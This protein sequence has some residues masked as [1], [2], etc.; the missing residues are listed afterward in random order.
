MSTRRTGLLIVSGTVLVAVVVGVVVLISLSSSSSATLQLPSV[1]PARSRFP[2][3]PPGAV[4]YAREDRM[5]AL[6]LAVVPGAHGVSLQASVVGG[7]GHGVRGLHVSFAVGTSA[8]RYTTTASP[9][10]SGCYR[11]NVA[12]PLRPLWVRM[13][14]ARATRT[15]T[16]NVRLPATWPTHDASAIVARA[17]KVWTH[18]HT[19][20][21][22][23][24]L[25][26]SPTDVVVAHWQVVAP[27]RLAYQIDRGS[28]AIIIGLR[29][30][31]RP[32][33]KSGTPWASSSA[34]RLQQPKPFW[35][36]ATDAHVLGS[37]RFGGH[38]VWR[39]SFF[40]PRTPGWFLA[41]IDKKTLRTLDLHMTATAH[42]MHD[43]YGPFNAPIRIDPPNR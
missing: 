40:D 42:F 5:D 12:L 21:Y 27:D 8:H 26:S 10:G 9:C 2:S 38:A 41:L 14:V 4:V 1:A 24:R 37:G 13:Q 33:Q 18:L 31:D 6:A 20:S 15:T 34:L 39:L 32:S 35:V 36:S 23:D 43:T 25:G 22:R 17:T 11:A 30:W 7:Q 28:Q 19:L 3:P 29:R 16:W